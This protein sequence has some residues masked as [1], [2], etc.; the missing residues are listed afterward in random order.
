MQVALLQGWI[1][2]HQL[3][4]RTAKCTCVLVIYVVMLRSC[5]AASGMNGE[6]PVNSDDSSDEVVCSELYHYE[7]AFNEFTPQL[8]FP[9][10]VKIA[11]FW[12]LTNF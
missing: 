7:T 3:T 1:M 12:I 6:S 4:L 9:W 11:R 5:P 8:Y 10:M 2:R